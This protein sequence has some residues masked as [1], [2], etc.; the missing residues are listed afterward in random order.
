[1][2]ADQGNWETSGKSH[3]D[4]GDPSA[5]ERRYHH[6]VALMGKYH[7][8]L[9]SGE[10]FDV[11]APDNYTQEQVFDLARQQGGMS[12]DYP[13]VKGP[14]LP[15]EPPDEA[16]RINAAPLPERN[17]GTGIGPLDQFLSTGNEAILG[18]LEGMANMGAAIGDIPEYWIR[19][20]IFGKE[21][22]E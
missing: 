3:E 18:G 6:K 10:A 11:E 19:R 4:R 14:D 13:A 16:A 7:V 5:A 21:N 12:E 8:T 2:G 1:F 20:G 15:S 9:P 17:Q 22:A